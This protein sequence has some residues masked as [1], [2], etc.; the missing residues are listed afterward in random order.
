MLIG[1]KI[2]IYENKERDRITL[3]DIFKAKNKKKNKKKNKRKE[4]NMRR[5]VV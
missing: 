4:Q 3:K 5:G 2:F 1:I